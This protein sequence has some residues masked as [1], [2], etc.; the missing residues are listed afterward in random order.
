MVGQKGGQI[1]GGQKQRVAIARAILK[2]PRILL[3]DEATSAL[4]T[5]SERLVQAALDKASTNRTTLVIAHRL[6]TIR[7]ADLIVVM[8]KGVI[9][10]QGTH[11]GLYANKG[12]YYRL[13]EA[14][15]VRKATETTDVIH[16]PEELTP[17]QASADPEKAATKMQM[18][19]PSMQTF[20]EKDDEEDKLQK[21][22]KERNLKAF[23][24]WRMTDYLFPFDYMLIAVCGIAA[25]IN[26]AVSITSF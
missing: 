15:E 2:N 22:I 19:S 11:E 5:E 23:S 8:E 17:I 7:H 14:Q 3:L 25:M 1:S 9:V 4:D 6:S 16:S 20:K 12:M 26:G 13:V 18:K 21:E 10:E 24:W